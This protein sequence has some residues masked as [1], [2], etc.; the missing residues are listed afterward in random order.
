MTGIEVLIARDTEDALER[1]ALEEISSKQLNSQKMELAHKKAI[2]NLKI[3][4][5]QKSI[6]FNKPFDIL[7]IFRRNVCN[8]FCTCANSHSLHH[9]NIIIIWC[10]HGK[11]Y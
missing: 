1:E 4:Y 3:N 6:F 2:G 9:Y 11:N 8:V 5:K 10:S 7:L